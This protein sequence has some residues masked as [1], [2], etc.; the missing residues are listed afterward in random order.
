VV[1]CH[2]GSD[3]IEVGQ[4]NAYRRTSRHAGD[5]RRHR[6]TV[7]AAGKKLATRGLA[8]LADA[9]GERLARLSAS[10][11]AELMRLLEALS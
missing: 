4:H 11:Q 3:A 9:F 5:L 8:M 1:L 6:L 2:R 10:D 7:T